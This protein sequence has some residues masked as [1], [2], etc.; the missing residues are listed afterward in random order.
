LPCWPVCRLLRC[1]CCSCN[2]TFFS[3]LDCEAPTSGFSSAVLRYSSLALG[4]QAS[5]NIAKILRRDEVF[6]TSPPVHHDLIHRLPQ[7]QAH[8]MSAVPPST[9]T[10]RR[11]TQ[12]ASHLRHVSNGSSEG[13]S[14]PHTAASNASTVQHDPVA[15]KLPTERKCIIWVHEEAFSKDDVIFDLDLFPDVKP[16]ELM[17][18]LALKA[19]PGVRDFQD[20]PQTS[21]KDGD[22]LSTAMHRQRSNSGPESP[23]TVNGNARRDSDIGKRYLFIAQAMSKEMKSKQPSLEISVAKHIADLF[24]LK[25]RSQVLVSTV[26]EPISR[27]TETLVTEICRLMLLLLLL[28]MLSFRSKM[29]TCLALICGDWR[30]Q[31]FP[32]RQSSKARRYCLSVA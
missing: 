21:K 14:R 31:S 24:C 9:P 20:Q 28:P 27:A 5:V 32:I 17:G 6:Q 7:G 13:I 18:V 2:R 23:S 3:E 1:W 19:E 12:Q 4:A 26:S 8:S 29:S 16:G 15:V 30:S 25:H 22:T 11:G 10:P